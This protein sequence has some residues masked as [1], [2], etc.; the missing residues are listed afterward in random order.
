MLDHVLEQ[1]LKSGDSSWH[2][3][4]LA[5]IFVFLELPCLLEAD[6][7]QVCIVLMTIIVFD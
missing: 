7:L 6:L 5:D 2:I 3:S 4:H 1:L